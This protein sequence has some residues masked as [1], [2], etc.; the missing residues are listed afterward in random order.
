MSDCNQLVYQGQEYTREELKKL[1]KEGALSAPS[2]QQLK[3]NQVG[4]IFQS[5]ILMSTPKVQQEWNKLK[6]GNITFEQFLNNSQF[7]KEQKAIVEEV[8]NESKPESLDDFAM[9]LA[10]KYSYTVEVNTAT[11]YEKGIE[12]DYEFTV[13]GDKYSH[14]FEEEMNV[15]GEYDTVQKFYKNGIEIESY[16]YLEVKL[17]AFKNTVREKKHT[18]YY[19]NLTAPGHQ[20]NPDWEYV[21]KEIATPGITPSIKGHAQF[22]TS[23]GIGWTRQSINKKTKTVAVEELQSDLFQK[24]RDKDDL[25]SKN[26]ISS[27]DTSATQMQLL[28]QKLD[29]GEITIDEY[30]ELRKQYDVNKDKIDSKENQFLQLLNK[31]GNWI[32]FFIKTI[33]Q[34]SA[35]KGYEKVLFPTGDTASKIEGHET[36][37]GFKADKENSIKILQKEKDSLENGGSIRVYN[38]KLGWAEET[39]DTEKV[40]S[41]LST[42]SREIE[43]LQ[44]ELKRV[45]TEGIASFK[46]IYDF[47]ENRV[48]NTLNKIYGKDNITRIKDEYGNEWYQLNIEDEK[49]NNV[50]ANEIDLFPRQYTVSEQLKQIERAVERFELHSAI[51]YNRTGYLNKSNKASKVLVDKMNKHF[52]ERRNIYPTLGVRLQMFGGEDALIQFVSTKPLTKDRSFDEIDFE[53]SDFTP[54][55]PDWYDETVYSYKERTSK[56]PNTVMLDNPTQLDV[57]LLKAQKIKFRRSNPQIDVLLVSEGTGLEQ[58]MVRT[59]G[60]NVF[61]KEGS[62]AYLNHYNDVDFTNAF[63]I[64]RTNYYFLT[65]KFRAETIPQRERRLKELEVNKKGIYLISGNSTGTTSS[66]KR[67]INTSRKKVQQVIDH[68]KRN[69]FKVDAF[70]KFSKEEKENAISNS[71]NINKDTLVESLVSTLLTKMPFLNKEKVSDILNTLPTNVLTSLEFSF[72][73][74]QNNEEYR[75]IVE[76]SFYARYDKESEL[77]PPLQEY[78]DIYEEELNKALLNPSTSAIIST[79]LAEIEKVQNPENIKQWEKYKSNVLGAISQTNEK[80]LNETFSTYISKEELI[81]LNSINSARFRRYLLSVNGTRTK[82]IDILLNI[83]GWRDQRNFADSYLSFGKDLKGKRLT[84]ILEGVEGVD[85]LMEYNKAIKEF[86]RFVKNNNLLKA[87]RVNDTAFIELN[88]SNANINDVFHEIGHFL[89]DLGEGKT[90]DEILSL[91]WEYNRRDKASNQ[92][93]DRSSN[94]SLDAYI[95]KVERIYK[96]HDK[97]FSKEDLDK[98]LFANFYSA[99]FTGEGE[100]YDIINKSTKYKGLWDKLVNLLK[101]IFKSIFGDN[102]AAQTFKEK[103]E[104]LNN[105]ISEKVTESVVIGEQRIEM[106][107]Y[108][109]KYVQREEEINKLKDKFEKSGDIEFDAVGNITVVKVPGTDVESPLFK[110]LDENFDSS[111]ALDI[112]LSTHTEQFKEYH[113]HTEEPFVNKYGEPILFFHGTSTNYYSVDKAKFYSGEGFMAYGAG[114]YAT[115]H[116][117]TSV[118]YSRGTTSKNKTE[119]YKDIYAKLFNPKYI[120]KDKNP[121]RQELFVAPR[122]PMGIDSVITDKLKSVIIEAF[123]NVEFVEKNTYHSYGT[124]NN[125]SAYNY[126][127]KK[128]QIDNKATG[129]IVYNALKELNPTTTPSDVWVSNKLYEAGIEALYRYAGGAVNA[130]GG[131]HKRGEM[132]IIIFDSNP[133]KDVNNIGSFDRNNANK[134]YSLDLNGKSMDELD[135]NPQ[136]FKNMPFKFSGNKIAAGKKMYTVRTQ[137]YKMGTYK[138]NNNKLFNV[139]PEGKGFIH[140]YADA[141]GITEQEFVKEFI[142]DEEIKYQHIQDFISG[143]KEL[144]IYRIEKVT[145]KDEIIP[146]ISD[147]RFAKIYANRLALIQRIKRQ[148]REEQDPNKAD[149]LKARLDILQSQAKTLYN[150]ETRSFGALLSMLRSDIATAKRILDSKWDRKSLEFTKGLVANYIELIT[151]DFSD[152]YKALD[153]PTKDATNDLLD[154]IDKLLDRINKG[155]V[156]IAASN[157]KRISGRD[158]LTIDGDIEIVDDINV[159]AAETYP[160]KWNKNPIVQ[161][162]SKIV[163][164]AKITAQTAFS[165]FQKSHRALVK[166]LKKDYDFMIQTDSQGKKTGNFVWKSNAEYERLNEESFLDP[167]SR[168][169]FLAQNHTF[170]VND[171]AWKERE[172]R[173]LEYYKNNNNIV[174]S[175]SE[176]NRG[177]SLDDKIERYAYEMTEKVNPHRM[178]SIFDRIRSN[179]KRTSAKDVEYYIKFNDYRG[180]YPE[181]ING[182]WDKTIEKTV[183]N[184]WIDSKWEAIQRLPDTDPKKQFYNHWLEY[185]NKG[186]SMRGDESRYIPWNRIPEKTKP[187]GIKTWMRQF[188]YDSFGQSISYNKD[189]INTET[190]EVERKIPLYLSSGKMSPENMSYNLGAIL[191]SYVKELI[192]Y[193]EKVAVEEPTNFMLDLLKQQPVYEST[194]DGKR[195][196]VQGKPQTKN[197]V[198]NNYNQ[199]LHFV[200]AVIYGEYQKIEG[201]SSTILHSAET[202]DEMSKVKKQVEALNIS[203]TEKSE[204]LAHIDN[205]VPYVGNNTKI[206]EYIEL[207]MKYKALSNTGKNI[208]ASKVLNTGMFWTAVKTLGL[209]VFAGLG[210]VLQGIASLYSESSANTYFG[211]TAATW[212]IGKYLGSRNPL[213][214]ESNEWVNS[215]IKHF[216]P[217]GEIFHESEKQVKTGVEKVFFGLYR[218]GN[219]FSN[220]VF[221]LAMLKHLK[222]TDKKGVERSVAESIDFKDGKLVWKYDIDIPLYNDEGKPTDYHLNL[223]HRSDEVLSLNRGR[224]AF[225]DPTKLSSHLV[226]RIL[227]Q[228]KENWLVGMFYNRFGAEREGNLT[229][230]ND[231][232]GF[233]RTFLN[234]ILLPPM[235]KNPITGIEER[236]TSITGLLTIPLNFAKYLV[237]FSTIGKKAGLLKDG[238]YSPL[239]EANLRKFMREFSIAITLYAAITILSASRDDG[240]DDPFL[241][242]V[243]NQLIRLQRD[244][245]TFMSL[246]SL[247]SF[248]ENPMPITS[249]LTDFIR[250]VDASRSTI[251]EDPYNRE[252]DS[253]LW[254]ATSKAIPFINKLESTKRKFDEKLIYGRY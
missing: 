99:V 67:A 165:T 254:K 202:K 163:R 109:E 148:L 166:S 59:E 86:N 64:K 135:I 231:F 178:K 237:K 30:R 195:K 244:V 82:F 155:Y 187:L 76:K 63:K 16:E 157:V 125:A 198:S 124:R 48:K 246:E 160:V 24:S 192:D 115:S 247:K 144:Y 73:D 167:R 240:D 96:S 18:Q 204:A 206:S 225:I 51:K 120:N 180:F 245:T 74:T 65:D 169:I 205:D 117:P 151:K 43:Q 1:L 197:G 243:M 87:T 112:W 236:D 159:A 9:E 238:K 147:P 84:N 181:K 62:P 70:M 12:S 47:Y 211:D 113:K 213:S 19:S 186:N 69:K 92:L 183:D 78:S 207:A 110:I 171:A 241:T 88:A 107:L 173:L 111:Q 140:E 129:W 121:Y 194:I 196:I 72:S 119:K 142:G 50:F 6:K 150:D 233:Y 230:G 60:G 185:I 190:G 22:S 71:G 46:P 80:L 75:A 122:N 224:K 161:S 227:G 45:E 145:S 214:K 210:E 228:F 95:K 28:N 153:Q 104:Q 253:K 136:D 25:I 79:V 100:L 141:K 52:D 199:A 251:F 203:N 32:P 133:I 175:D 179:A 130:F 89:Y 118:S 226:G 189:F 127:G 116:A 201:V 223:I 137:A 128:L 177:V 252:G 106:K 248:T 222:V 156:S 114:L 232:E 44:E 134:Y 158:V 182:K 83:Q 33:I 3:D 149:D 14:V 57:N 93:L 11:Y 23:N 42:L 85:E 176:L 168:L 105:E 146:E 139:F 188:G 215:I 61:V 54:E 208:T 101:N 13:N 200:N 108:K 7:P 91:I 8:Y 143:I 21:E 2:F 39:T 164:D 219:H 250:I 4:Y 217:I 41:R 94:E 37:E 170:I 162:I 40:Q 220:T 212:A 102:T 152:I 10:S 209:D 242:Y 68:F 29:N 15:G 5:V 103:F 66:E 216:D 26:S 36:L 49:Y 172:K 81:M 53:V 235:R 234:E 90:R 193:E 138:A 38:P 77:F 184:K 229:G 58:G 55:L 221:T 249:T 31:D 239:V 154:D 27:L 97:N 191:E 20:N 56:Q 132:H 34:D 17:K 98:E 218:A 174:L 131:Q 123:P 126:D 35:K